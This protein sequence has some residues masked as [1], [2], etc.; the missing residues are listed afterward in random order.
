[1]TQEWLISLKTESKAVVTREHFDSH[2]KLTPSWRVSSRRRLVLSRSVR[3][4][5]SKFRRW[6][7]SIDL[8][9]DDPLG[10]HSPESRSNW[11]NWVRN[12]TISCK[13]C[14]CAPMRRHQRRALV[15]PLPLPGGSLDRLST[16]S[17]ASD[18]IWRA[19]WR[20]QRKKNVRMVKQTAG[21]KCQMASLSQLTACSLVP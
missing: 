13:R 16:G 18:L 11:A 21:T 14:S 5:R 6:L 19:I 7:R 12:R 9:I 1:M 15:E 4:A 8:R 17:L 3:R 20:K 2:P 10:F